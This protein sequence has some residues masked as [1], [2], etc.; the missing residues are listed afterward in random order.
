VASLQQQFEQLQRDAANLV[1]R[2]EFGQIVQMSGGV[3]LN[4]A[5]SA[6]ATFY[7]YSLPANK[8]ELWMALESERFL[9]PVFREFYQEQQVILE[10]RRMRT[11]NNP[12]GQMVEAFLD[13]AFTEHPY[14]R[15]VIGYDEDIRNLSRQ[16]VQDFYDQFYVPSNM[17]IAVVGDVDPANVKALAETYFGRFPQRPRPPQVKTIEPP[18]PQAKEISLTLQSQPW[19]FE[20]Y[21]RPAVSDPDD[22][23]YDVMATILSSGRTS[24]L[25]QSLVEQKQLALVAQGFNGFP[26]EKFPNLMLFY[27]QSAPGQNLEA[28]SQALH[29]EIE[30][31]KTEPVTPEELE[32]AQ[33]LLQASVLRS[34]DSNTGMAELL[35]KYQVLTGDWRNLFTQLQAIANV[36]PEDIQRV[37]NQTFRPE[38]RTIGRI[39]P[40]AE[41]AQK[42]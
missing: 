23:V 8:L 12:V 21:H 10:E 38:N 41:P 27:A 1:E 20:G 15:P 35:V 26:G 14:K 11:E 32:R 25:Y 39:L 7:F 40:E 34:L 19:Y 24:R 31:L 6:D 42:P 5:T 3:G 29:G 18:Q 22:V 4:A 2:N 33:N 13:K 36:T 28:V 9:N 16:D 30:R 17:T 37:A